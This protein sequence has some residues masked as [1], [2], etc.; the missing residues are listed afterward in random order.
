MSSALKRMSAN[1]IQG[2]GGIQEYISLMCKMLRSSGDNIREVMLRVMG[3]TGESQSLIT[4]YGQQIID[5]C[6]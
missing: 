4:K 6:V 3:D 5:V 2:E 1:M